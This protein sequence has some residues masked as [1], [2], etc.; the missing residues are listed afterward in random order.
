MLASGTAAAGLL[1]ACQS[2][3]QAASQRQAPA[4]AAPTAAASGT[5]A[6]VSATSASGAPA[7]TLPPKAGGT[8]RFGTVG[9]FTTLDGHVIIP[10]LED[11]VWQVWDRLTAKDPQNKPQ[12]MLAESFEQS[13]DGKTLTLHL[14][15]GVTF[16][17]GRE[18]TSEDVKWNLTRSKDP[19]V[20]FG[21]LASL[22]ASMKSFD[23]PDKY[24][25][26]L[27]SDTPWPAVYDFLEFL[28]ILDP[29]T[30]QGPDAKTKAVGTGPFVWTEYAPG[31]H[32]RLTRNKN[33]WRSGAPLL[34][35]INIA[36]QRDPQAMI[37]QLQAGA[38]DIADSPQLTD[39]V[40]L[41]KDP[42]FQVVINPYTGG[43]NVVALNATAPPTDNKQV[44]QALNY[45]LDRQRIAQTVFKGLMKP[46]DLPWPPISAAYEAQK[47]GAYTFDLDKAKSLIAASGLSDIAMDINTGAT[48]TGSGQDIAQIYQEDLAKIG[49]K[50]T[51]K[52]ADPVTF[53]TGL[54]NH[55]L[56]GAI[57]IIGFTAQLHPATVMLGPYYSPFF[58]YSGYKDNA[59]TALVNQATTETDPAKAKDLYSRWNDYVLDQSWILVSC[60]NAQIVAAQPTVKGIAWNMHEGLDLSGV[61]VN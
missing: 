52:P 47:V 37:T 26:V 39:V 60:N 30:M 32:V 34:D 42:K 28:N 21:I 23:T 18:L 38:L 13:S 6:S 36:I 44:R 31:D 19:K 5:S 16:H 58:N 55:T 54:A 40:T 3:Q 25:V 51:I 9:D 56:N 49:V 7:T 45:A 15:K 41:Q 22:G 53:Q 43:W 29:D 10:N 12:P 61:G 11:T 57:V 33:Y 35:E 24:T 14:R 48:G 8:L 59:Y 17:T 1:A 50:A 46:Q 4:P 20:G 2:A 27:N